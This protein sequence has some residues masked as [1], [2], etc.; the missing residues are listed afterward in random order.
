MILMMRRKNGRELY[1]VFRETT[2]SGQMVPPPA[3]SQKKASAEEGAS[4][5]THVFRLGD[6]R[7]AEFSLSTGWTYGIIVLVILLASG[8]FMLGRHFGPVSS[9]TPAARSTERVVSG[10]A[11][12]GEAGLV[13]TATSLAPASVVPAAMAVQQGGYTVRCATYT[14]S[15]TGR[16]RAEE[17]AADLR[18]QGFANV[19]VLATKDRRYLI[20][21]VGVF[22]T[23]QDATQVKDRIVRLPEFRDAI[24][25][26][27]KDYE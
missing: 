2:A 3:Q 16:A 10:A 13:N 24:L 6:E 21:A 19:R 1:E 18:A 22:A 9:A 12:T 20:L 23:T 8:A 15:Q 25:S 17:A 26:Q 27:L 4:A 7:Y 11:R 14:N 5:K